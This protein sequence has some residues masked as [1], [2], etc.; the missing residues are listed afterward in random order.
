MRLPLVININLPSILYCFQVTANYMSNFRQ[1]Q[2]DA[3]F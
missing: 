1:R 3:T 2:E